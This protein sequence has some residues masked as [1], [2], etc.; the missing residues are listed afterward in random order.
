MRDAGPLLTAAAERGAIVK[1][2][3]V[4]SAFQKC[5]VFAKVPGPRAPKAPGKARKSVS[6]ARKPA[7]VIIATA[8]FTLG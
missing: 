1:I 5:V 7:L 8:H 2:F 3:E 4:H 6:A